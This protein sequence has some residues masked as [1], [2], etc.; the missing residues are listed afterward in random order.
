MDIVE[1]KRFLVFS[2]ENYYPC[3]GVDDIKDTSDNLEEAISIANEDDGEY[4][5]VFD[6]DL[7]KIVY[8]KK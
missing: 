8:D 6:C 7:R 2:F 1:Y 4:V 5:Y 3:G